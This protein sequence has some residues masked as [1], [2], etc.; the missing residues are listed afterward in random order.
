MMS[1]LLV[2]VGA[3][4]GAIARYSLVRLVTSDRYG[5]ALAI[6]MANVAGSFLL[7]VIVVIAS[8]SW[9]LFAG[10]GFCGTL[11]TFSTFAIDVI[12][13]TERRRTGTAVG[14]AVVSVVVCLAVAGMGMAIGTA[15]T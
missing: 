5:P 2:A 8:P 4:L 14:Y 9:L 7:G 15:L 12:G 6:L 10:V 3:F 11:T 13:F 1:V